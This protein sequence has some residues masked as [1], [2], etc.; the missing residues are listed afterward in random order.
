MNFF[1]KVKE[2][3]I[4]S[5]Q[6][7]SKKVK[8]TTETMRLQSENKEKGKEIEKLLYQ[9]GMQYFASFPEECEKHFPEITAKIKEAQAIIEKNNQTIEN[10]NNV[11]MCPSCGKPLAAGAMF[12]VYCGNK[13]VNEVQKE[14]VEEK[15]AA[16]NE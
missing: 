6:D 9:I 8:E 7:V 3:I 11:P 4:E 15:G 14:E 13:I 10:I 16:D 2:S 5:S 12:C 1:N